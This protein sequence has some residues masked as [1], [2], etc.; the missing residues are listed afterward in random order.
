VGGRLIT[1]TGSIS[2]QG[3]VAVAR[4]EATH[5]AANG[6][7][8]GQGTTGANGR[9]DQAAAAGDK[10]ATDSVRV[11]GS[12][13]QGSAQENESAA[14]DD[15]RGYTGDEVVDLVKGKAASDVARQALERAG[16]FERRYKKSEFKE[17]MDDWASVVDPI[18]KA[19]GVEISSLIVQI[20]ESIYLHGPFSDGRQRA[21][22]PLSAGQPDGL[23]LGFIHTHP[24]NHSVSIQDRLVIQ[25]M[26]RQRG[27]VALFAIATKDGVVSSVYDSV[28]K[29]NHPWENYSPP[30]F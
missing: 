7:S 18:A 2:A 28:T 26:K 1:S 24:F 17:A 25:P 20:E 9:K 11:S 12:A 16:L 3:N 27:V 29:S 15:R 13:Q 5:A 10:K 21:V 8:A 4:H 30:A 23:I 22:G 6:A 19:H 14:D